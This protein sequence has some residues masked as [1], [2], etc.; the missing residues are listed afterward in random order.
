MNGVRVNGNV[1]LSHRYCCDLLSALVLKVP[2]EAS[3]QQALVLVLE[4]PY[5]QRTYLRDLRE[6]NVQ[7]PSTLYVTALPQPL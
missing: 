3:Q 1:G 2:R 5:G 4:G 6:C 7:I